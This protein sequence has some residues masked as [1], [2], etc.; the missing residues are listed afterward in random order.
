MG[1]DKIGADKMGEDEIGS[2]RSGNIPQKVLFTSLTS[3]RTKS[4][5][6]YLLNMMH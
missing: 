4:V 5:V 1:V 3:P 6:S 2:R